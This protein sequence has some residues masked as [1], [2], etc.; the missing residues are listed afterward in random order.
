[1]HMA[2]YPAALARDY[3]LADG[4]TVT[5]RPIRAGDAV[6]EAE[7]L[8][9]LSWET[10][11]FRFHKFVAAP[12]EKLVHFFTDID[13][14]RHMAF[15]CVHATERGE[16]IVGEARYVVNP[17]DVSCDFGIVIA[18]AWQKTGIA[19]LL[20]HRLIATARERGL[21][22]MEGLVLSGN[23]RM[24]RFARALGFE[25]RSMPEDPATKVIVKQLANSP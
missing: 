11:Y 20:M 14:E 17:D 25:I 12:S 21:Q 4:R 15:V 19:G 5:I 6:R 1:M 23:A 24:L 18:D 10:L 3:R 22:R 13:Y 9:G 8:R 16:E 7:F 2:E